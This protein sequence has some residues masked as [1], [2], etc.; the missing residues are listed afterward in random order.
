MYFCVFNNTDYK[1]KCIPDEKYK[2]NKTKNFTRI[3]ETDEA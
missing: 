2:Q 1:G 3:D